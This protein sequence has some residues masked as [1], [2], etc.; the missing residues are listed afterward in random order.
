MIGQISA[1]DQAAVS[2]KLLGLDDSIAPQHRRAR[3]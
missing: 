1:F 3:S 2:I